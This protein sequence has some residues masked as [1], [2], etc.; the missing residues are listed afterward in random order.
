MTII[1]KIIGKTHKKKK[2][3][4][5]QQ[6]LEQQQKNI[7]DFKAILWVLLVFLLAV[8]GFFVWSSST[9]PVDKSASVVSSEAQ[10]EPMAYEFYE[11][12]PKQGFYS[13]SEVVGTKSSSP[14]KAV[15]LD[16][17]VKGDKT[18]G[19]VSYILQVRS[20]DNTKQADEQRTKVMMAGVDA[21]VVRHQ[22]QDKV[23]YQVVS[24]PFETQ[25][26][27]GRAAQ[28]LRANGIDV[29]LVEQRH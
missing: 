2:F 29:L 4:E 6:S 21:I 28:K 15:A 25:D 5:Y 9:E 3:A 1:D 27:A 20:Y 7:A 22:K 23:L 18:Q 19:K 16:A 8:V 24:R 12:L 26:K 13:L 10:A 11:L 17:V 14:S